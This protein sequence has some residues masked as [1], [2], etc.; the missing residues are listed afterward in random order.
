M[1]LVSKNLPKKQE[2]DLL[3]LMIESAEDYAIFM[4]DTYGRVATWNLGAERI[5]G[6][7]EQEIIGLNVS[8]FCT[9]DDIESGVSEREMATAR[10]TGRAES[11]RWQV[12]KNGELFWAKGTLR[13]LY[14]DGDLVGYAKIMRDA[15]ESK[16]AEDDLRS[17]HD[18]T[19]EILESISD[20]FYA[21]DTD[22]NFTYLNRKSEEWLGRSREDLIGR[23]YWTTF[24]EIAQSES[25]K[26][27]ADA[28]AARQ[29]VHYETILPIINR[30]VDVSVY[31]SG[32]GLSVYVRDIADRKRREYKV[33]V[34]LEKQSN[35]ADALQRAMLPAKP[36]MHF[37]GLDVA[38]LYESALDEAKVG[39]DFCDAFV[40]RGQKVALLVGDVSGKGL[41]AASRTA[42]VRYSL[43]AFGYYSGSP[44]A[45]LTRLNSFVSS[46]HADDDTGEGTFVAATM[47]VVDP[48]DGHVTVSIAG[49]DPVLILKADGTT[50]TVD[51]SGLPI[52]VMGDSLYQTASTGVSPGDTVIIATDGIME[53]RNGTEMLGMEGMARIAREAGPQSSLPDL[54]TAIYNGALQFAGGIQRDDACVLA[55]RLV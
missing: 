14:D 43:R 26:K 17:A 12:R 50:Q 1:V 31:P 3:Q 47:A 35:I 9:P 34:A 4:I 13:P 53:S 15:T 2:A 42:E 25:F 29:P 48:R 44:G 54:L 33:G 5:L 55:A 49:A 8:N 52:G 32:A 7:A 24:P 6:Y 36:V 41:L 51:A 22:F 46:A 18:H 23:H 39:G 16:R 21:V 37:P 45:A 20:A 30:W 38:M 10:T 27:H 40:V 19:V 28:M 11:E